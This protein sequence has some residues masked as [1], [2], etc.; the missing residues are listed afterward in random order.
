MEN[1]ISVEKLIKHL[2][3]VYNKPTGA[4]FLPDTLNALKMCLDNNPNSLQAINRLVDDCEN[5]LFTMDHPVTSY[6]DAQ[7]NYIFN[8]KL[9]TIEL[10]RLG[11]KWESYD[12]YNNFKLPQVN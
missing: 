2:D 8:L 11:L 3:F 6:R 9:L 7:K 10:Q 5:D 12:S 1:I 4:W